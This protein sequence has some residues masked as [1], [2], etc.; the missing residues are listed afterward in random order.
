[1]VVR[2]ARW[3]MSGLVRLLVVLT[4]LLL[5]TVRKEVTSGIDCS[6]HMPSEVVIAHLASLK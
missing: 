5:K 2:S 4:L 6:C 3:R 1:M